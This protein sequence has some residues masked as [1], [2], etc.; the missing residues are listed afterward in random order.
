LL[1]DIHNDCG[2]NFVWIAWKPALSLHEFQQQSEAEAVRTGF[3]GDQQA[4]LWR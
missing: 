3:A 1:R 4:L 2:W